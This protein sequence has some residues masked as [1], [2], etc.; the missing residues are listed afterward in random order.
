MVSMS[1][2][3]LSLLLFLFAPSIFSQ[4]IDQAIVRLVNDETLKYGMMSFSLIDRN[5]GEV[6]AT[7]QPNLALIP[8]STLKILT[9]AYGLK[10]LGVN[11][12][13]RTDLEVSGNIVD[14]G[15]LKGNLFIKGFGDPTFGSELYGNKGNLQKLLEQIYE[16]IR[17]AGI[18]TIEGDVYGDANYMTDEGIIDSWSWYDLG[19]YYA[20]GIY[21]LNIYDNLFHL[22]F[23]QSTTGSKP[24]I[25]NHYPA[26]P[27]L[28][29]LS[30]VVSQGKSDN[31][32]IYGG[33]FQYARVVRGSI[34][35][36]NGKFAIKGSM[37][38]PPLVAAQ[39]IRDYLTQKGIAVKGKAYSSLVTDLPK[40]KRQLV[41]SY[42]SAPLSEI[43]KQ[44]LLNSNNLFS[45]A[46]LRQ[47]G[48]KLGPNGRQ[49]DH[50]KSYRSFLSQYAQGSEG[51]FVQDGSGLSPTNAVPSLGFATFL[52]QILLDKE[53]SNII[54]Q[55]LPVLGESGTL[56]N[57]CNGMPVAGK[58]KAKTGSMD[59]VRSFSGII[60]GKSGKEYL[61]SMIINNY[62]GNSASIKS[63]IEKFFQSLWENT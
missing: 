33:P 58:I 60:I 31:A 29:F 56:K 13:F 37:P 54:L 2:W 18:S 63:K 36:G 53:I 57:W 30:E 6:K 59:R 22:D 27:G 35:P 19:N 4:D 5:S 41:K 48:E 20:S 45:E 25:A 10:V 24:I 15:I 42:F 49:A 12:K 7:H 9:C 17:G 34:P 39:L 40:S 32:Y 52:R 47:S 1:K 23:Q 21:G 61:F 14:G 46:I 28:K 16:D 51:F 50:I 44:T 26:I 8:A 3:Y 55:S 43:V 62:T 11:Y 38:D